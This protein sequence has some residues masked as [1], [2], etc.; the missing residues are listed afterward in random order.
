MFDIVEVSVLELGAGL[1]DGVFAM[2]DALVSGA[3]LVAPPATEGCARRSFLRAGLGEGRRRASARADE[4][5]ALQRAGVGPV[6]IARRL[7]VS[8]MTVWRKLKAVETVDA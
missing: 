4:I 3:L 6:E 2:G 8:R 5:F 7:G 1:A